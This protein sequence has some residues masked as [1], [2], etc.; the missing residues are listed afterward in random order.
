MSD[1]VYY[2]GKDNRPTHLVASNHVAN[3]IERAAEHTAGKAEGIDTDVREN[4]A[5]QSRSHV[6]RVVQSGKRIDDD[7][8]Y[9]AVCHSA[10]I[11]KQIDGNGCH[12]SYS[13]EETL[14]R[15]WRQRS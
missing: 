7:T 12:G 3:H 8:F 11:V 6:V 5:H 10:N 4:V 14:N 2:N 15:L 1:N 13:D 9:R